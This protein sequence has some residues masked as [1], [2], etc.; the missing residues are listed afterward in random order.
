MSRGR[1]S[2]RPRGT[3]RSCRQSARGQN[4]TIMVNGQRIMVNGQQ[5]TANGQWLSMVNELAGIARTRSESYNNGQQS[6]DNGQWSTING[7]RP[8]VVN[9]Q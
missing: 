6:T 9:G 4:P 1:T 3:S 2:C 8:M 5:S 7:K